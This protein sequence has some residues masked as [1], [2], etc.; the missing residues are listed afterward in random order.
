MRSASSMM[1]SG[2]PVPAEIAVWN[3]SYSSLPW[4]TFV[5]QAWTSSLPSLKLSTTLSMLG[6][7]PQTDT[8]G[9]SVFVILL[10]QLAASPP[11]PSVLVLLV[12]ALQPASSKVIAMA[13]AAASASLL[14]TVLGS[15]RVCVRTSLSVRHPEGRTS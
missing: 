12:S 7:Q 14:F 11:P 8:V 10:V 2:A 3:L 9:R 4:P 6:Y 1:T 13:D 15:L 5:Q